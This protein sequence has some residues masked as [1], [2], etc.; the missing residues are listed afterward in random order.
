MCTILLAWRSHPA[1]PV[2]L[3]ANRDE[4][5]ARPSAPPG[6]L[7]RRPLIVGGRDL[8]AG[9]TWLAVAADGTICAVTNR[10]PGEGPPL[11]PDPSRRSRGEI[12]VMLLTTDPADVPA[13]LAGLGP[14]RYNPVNVLWLSADRALVAHVDDSGPVRLV[15]LAPGPHVLT[16]RDVDDD[17]S[18]KVALLLAG[19]R[20]ALAAAAGD[21]SATM[22]GLRALLADHTSATD[23]PVDAACIHGDVY[24]T[25]SASTVSAGPDRL[26]Y[27]HAPGRPCVT[28]FAPVPM[29]V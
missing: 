24:G 10:H 4:L 18:L 8:V 29:T 20:R 3:A 16:T 26:T 17:R 11:S 28:P 9:G 12:P 25:V 15:D 23:S 7:R 2:V 27:Q 14:G 13:R 19:M 22:L 1:T 21:A 5:I 6:V